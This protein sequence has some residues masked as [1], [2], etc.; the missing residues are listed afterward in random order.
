MHKKI[1]IV[2]VDNNWAIGKNNKLLYSIPSDMTFFKNMTTGKIVIYGLNTLNSFPNQKPLPYRTNIVVSP[3]TI[4]KDNLY[5]A[6]SIEEIDEI[7]SKI[8]G[9][10]D[11]FVCGGAS[12]YKQMLNYCDECLIT[13]IDAT[14]EG[15]DTFFPNLNELGGWHK[16][17]CL[18]DTFDD[19]SQ[20]HIEIWRYVK[21]V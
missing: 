8:D 10:T 7:L 12:I 2:A 15:A 14:T 11:A 21:N 9:Y 3:D 18:L 19:K 13:H 17:E 20:L 16:K 5:T 4:H 6:H 1:A